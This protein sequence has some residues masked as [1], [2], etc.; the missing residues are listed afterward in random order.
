MPMNKHEMISVFGGV[1]LNYY[2][3]KTLRDKPVTVKN[4]T[5]KNK[6]SSYNFS[7]FGTS[8]K[9]YTYTHRNP[10]TIIVGK[11]MS[12]KGKQHPTQKPVELMEYVI[13]TYTNEGETVFDFTMGS[14]TTGVACKNLNRSFLGIEMD[15]KYFNI[16]KERIEQA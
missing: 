16:A 11:W 15:E 13:K 10:D 2:P 14:G 1:D 12:N 7:K 8:Q 6:D 4:Y 9:S 5:K 3:Q